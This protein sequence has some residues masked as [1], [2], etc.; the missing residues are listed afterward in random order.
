MTR[1]VATGALAVMI[2]G[3]AMAQDVEYEV[4]GEAF[5]GYFAAAE[6]PAGLVLIIHD[7]EGLDGYER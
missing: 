1:W 5:E 7:W 4:G 6:D 2:A 3:A